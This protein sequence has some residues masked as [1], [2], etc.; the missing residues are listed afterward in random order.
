MSEEAS[1]V[2]RQPL[3]FPS[4]GSSSAGS[5]TAAFSQYLNLL[6]SELTAAHTARPV[7]EEFS[8]SV[9][10]SP[11][12]LPGVRQLV[13]GGSL[14]DVGGVPNMDNPERHDIQFDLPELAKS[15]VH[16]R[17]TTSGTS[18]ASSAGA[19][20]STAASTESCQCLGAS[21]AAPI[22]AGCNAEGIL[23]C[24]LVDGGDTENA[25]HSDS[26]Y[27]KITSDKKW[28]PH[29]LH[30]YDEGPRQLLELPPPAGP[31]Q[32]VIDPFATRRYEPN[33]R[34]VGCLANLYIAKNHVVLAT[35]SVKTVAGPPASAAPTGDKDAV[36]TFTSTQILRVE[37]KKRV[38][39]TPRIHSFTQWLRTT[40]EAEILPQLQKKLA[41]QQAAHDPSAKFYP[42]DHTSDARGLGLGGV[43]FVRSGYVHG[44][45]MP[46]FLPEKIT[47][48]QQCNDWLR[49]FLCGPGH[50]VMFSTLLA[51]P[52][53]AQLERTRYAGM[54]LRTEHTHFFGSERC[55]NQGGH[56]HGD[57]VRQPPGAVKEAT[58][59]DLDADGER[60]LASLFANADRENPSSADIH[61]VAYLAPA[62]EIVRINDAEKIL[63]KQQ[64][65]LQVEGG[66][67]K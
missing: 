21:A 3:L 11:A 18:S 24:T 12:D 61:Y 55:A 29:A 10:T 59:H 4:A 45:V 42:D 35:D 41:Q 20:S 14:V 56:Y 5:Q 34:K 30:V 43:I 38:R 13:A 28:G 40:L 52:T 33:G 44:H 23:C 49:F 32:E 26:K 19:A 6:A 53:P 67:M 60:Y 62:A 65:N 17:T 36:F 64:K 50:L 2:E 31:G 57:V 27:T 51:L 9:V 15:V 22:V 16:G 63:A 54:H 39:T 7:Y 58:N 46:D 47:S 1:F 48:A 8:A 25:G 66:T 37:A